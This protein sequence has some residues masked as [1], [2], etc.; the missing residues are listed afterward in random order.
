MKGYSTIERRRKLPAISGY[1][2][3]HEKIGTPLYCLCIAS[4][5]V[6]LPGTATLYHCCSPFVGCVSVARTSNAVKLQRRSTAFGFVCELLYLLE[7]YVH[8]VFPAG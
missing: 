6:A 4:G 2:R 7:D 5:V 1:G 3:E 8:N